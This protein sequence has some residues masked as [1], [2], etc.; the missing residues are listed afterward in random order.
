MKLMDKISYPEAVGYIIEKLN[1]NGFEAFIVG[2]CV[3]DSI[4]GKLPCDWD[5]A[6]SA[7]P[8]DVKRLF[9]KTYDTG[10][11]H[12]TVSVSVDNS[13]Y[14]VTTYRIDG[15]YTDSRRPD[16]VSFT[17]DLKQDLARRDFTVNAMAYNPNTGL[18][19][20]FDGLKDI[21]QRQIKAVG[22]AGTRFL[23]DALRMLRAVRFSAQLGFSIEKN[24]FGAIAENA[25]SIKNISRERVRE[26]LNKILTSQEPSS[27]NKLYHS[28]LLAHIMPEFIPCYHTGQNNPYHIYNVADHII[29]TV[30]SI[31][32]SLILRWTML[33]HDIG[34]PSKKTTDDKGIDHFYG[35]QEASAELAGEILNR[36]RFDKLSIKK[37]LTL[38]KYHDIDIFDTEKS[39]R[40]VTSRLGEELFPSLLEV[41]RADAL[42]QNPVY[43]DKRLIKLDNI[44]HIYARIKDGQ[45][46]LSLSQMAVNGDDLIALGMKPGK[47]LK[48]VLSGLF[49]QVLEKPEI[50][51]RESLTELA[52]QLMGKYQ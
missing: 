38:V 48:E 32:D 16:N 22:D 17:S 8:V 47:E 52:R 18:I 44:K 40:R 43:L 3:R 25:G 39:V 51:S 36:L 15:H 41:Q 21:E 50:N 35:H 13:L 7:L 10:I 11:K 6:T 14:E 12:G 20:Y 24:T 37:I 28:G 31:P 49:E 29:R 23:E 5:I 1:E 26:E 33:L 19:D 27:F 9:K 42:G 2:G 34:K 46:C 30:E 4:L 45:H